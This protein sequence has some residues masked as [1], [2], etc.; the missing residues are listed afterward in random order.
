MRPYQV[1]VLD[2]FNESKCNGDSDHSEQKHTIGYWGRK[3][4][5]S[6]LDAKLTASEELSI[7]AVDG[8][9]GVPLVHE[10]YERESPRLTS[11]KVPG[12]VDI[13]KL[14][15]PEL[16]KRAAQQEEGDC[17]TGFRVRARARAPNGTNG[18]I[19]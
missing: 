3:K 10:A 18:T 1:P 5:T 6:Y 11:A 2:S 4:K 17:G 9:I 16:R 12:H 19:I 13:A 14:T 15:V 8:V 7:E